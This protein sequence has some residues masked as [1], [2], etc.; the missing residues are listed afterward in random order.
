MTAQR[1]T[2]QWIDSAGN[3]RRHDY[4]TSGGAAAVIAALIAKSNANIAEK[5]E[6][7]L[8]I[9]AGPATTAAPLQSVG[10]VA[11]LL[12]ST[13]SGAAVKVMLPAPSVGIFMADQE[14][15]DPTQITAII[16]AVLANTV[17]PA[18]NVVTAFVAGTRQ[19]R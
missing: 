9:T 16:A 17:D 8:V 11:E 6:G 15:V 2:A 7:P 12:F 19:R 13:A 14:T 1:E 4:T 18:G 3:T 10:D 5:W